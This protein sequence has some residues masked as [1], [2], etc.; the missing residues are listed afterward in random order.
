MNRP[1][2]HLHVHTEYSLLDGAIR[3]AE[4]ARKVASW[5]DAAGAVPA[6]A[7]TDHGA[8]YGVI[9]FYER[10][11]EN[12]VK[13]IIGCEIYVDPDGH[14]SREKK[15]KNNH[16]LLLAENAEGYHNLVKLASIAN[17]DG[18]YYKPRIDHDL[19]ARYSKGLIASSACLAGEIPQ[20]ILADKEKEA[21]DRAQLYQDIMG[22]GNFFLEVMINGLP[23]QAKVNKAL[24]QLSRDTGIPLAAT[25]DAHYLEKDDYEWHK[26]LLKVN[27]RAD[28]TDDAFGFSSND[29]YLRSPEEMNALFGPEMPGALDSTAEIAERCDV[30]FEL[31]SS[32]YQLPS[33]ELENGVTLEK[34][35]EDGA[36]RGLRLRMGDD[37]PE[38]YQKRLEY[39]L[40]VINSM[41]FAGYFLIVAGIIQ[42][43]KNRNIPIGPGRGSAAGSL[44]AWSLRITDLDPI[45][46][47]L[48]FE[49]FLNP[50]RITM[51]DIDTD[52]SD[53][54]RD[55]LLRY[56][57]E[58][59]GS[60]R[61]SQII[62]FGRMK[63]RQAVK[64]VGRAM[65]LEYSAMD[66]V[67]KLIPFGA[68]SIK[69]AVRSVPE[70]KEVIESD[71]QV[72]SAVKVAEKIEGLARHPSQHAAGV[73]ITPVP[74]T[75]LVPVR[76]IKAADAGSDTSGPLDLSQSMTQFT[77]EPIEK[78]G[79]VKMD[80]LG[81]STLSIIEETLE[82]IRVNGKPV[83][84]MNTIPMDDPAAYQMLQNADTLGIFQLESSGMRRLLLDLKVDCFEELIAVLAMYRPGPLGSGMV[85]QYV[86]CK[87]GRA[88]ATY[89][90]PLLEE[91]L[92]ET[93]GVILY[94]EQV[95]QCASILA[96]YTLG[97]ADLLRRAMGKKKV[98][99]MQQQRAK[100][101]TGAEKNKIDSKT[102]EHIFDLI[103]EFAG[104]GFNKSH[105]A[106]YAKISYHTA[107]LKANY[108]AEFMAAYLSSQMKAKKDVLGKYIRE[109][110]RSGVKVLPPD[111]NSSLESFTAVGD[112]IRFGLGAV[113]RVGHNAVQAVTA[114][115][116]ACKEGRFTSLWGFVSQVDIETVSKSAIENLIRAGAFDEISPNRA[117]LAAALPDFIQTAQKKSRD[118]GQYSLFDLTEEKPEEPD[119]PEREDDPVFE[120][121]E[122]EKEVMG[123]YISGHPFDAHEEK[124][125]KYATC[126]I[127]ELS[128]WK[129]SIP[130]K[131]GGIIL[132]VTDKITKS[133]KSMGLMNLEDSDAS[134]E[135]VSFPQDWETLKSQI[136]VG[137]PYIVEGRLGDREPR[138]LVVQK[139]T[140][141]K[142]DLDE[143]GLVRVR[144]RADLV[145]E[146]LNF[147]DFAVAL[148]D[149]PGR[150][151]VL[152]EFT[153][154]RDSCVLLLQGIGV[155]G[156]ENLQA[157]L[158]ELVPAGTFQVQGAGL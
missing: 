72:V 44:V 4:L 7:I 68:K 130:A 13:P 11:K 108:R 97:E 64:D 5:R 156:A 67:A 82:N 87:H 158:A 96:G 134:I 122:R 30:S 111:I 41:G 90:H 48:L 49:R 109:V 42:A 8:M 146:K 17:T 84:D 2:V 112:V 140:R 10:C 70:L 99:V 98:E 54:G 34:A 94:Q 18:Y 75:D 150:S 59:Y 40:E 50:E 78:L 65:G 101:V 110:R 36:L 61:V 128:F 33:M 116:A 153:D 55:E 114:A 56:I 27:T 83:P 73:V 115:R 81:L 3:T 148:K 20:F 131:V 113:T 45:A 123:I 155:G 138:N 9:E 29:Y 24:I 129:G 139:V 118:G 66:R 47:G 1:F 77:M 149:C 103:Q 32:A 88:K 76:R 69:E 58:R 39:E 133:G 14:R 95:M 143:P 26:I 136:Q 126:T 147:K 12:G 102:A 144:L 6:V 93:Y 105:S 152:V 85:K 151:P 142:E 15:G 37:P 107:Y 19:L 38:E 21:A 132:S 62:T 92:K 124:A 100:F 145:A 28:S 89:P 43:A 86:E 91:I 53:K 25:N 106:A 22:K 63:S 127:E 121:L 137:E 46:Y 79:L 80:F 117:R 52:V 57:V 157:R 51:P 60:D 31:G 23:A 141:L 135:M 71:P 119:M 120:R 154:E 104:Y 125:K 35:L 74:V 16:L